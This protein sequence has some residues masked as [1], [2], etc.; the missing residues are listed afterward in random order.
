[1]VEQTVL[2][3]PRRVNLWLEKGSDASAP[4][5]RVRYVT[6]EERSALVLAKKEAA[7]AELEE[8]AGAM[9]ILQVIR[10]SGRPLVGHNFLLDLLF[11]YSHFVKP[12]LP[13][14][15]MGF[16]TK[17]QRL[18]SDVRA[19]VRACEAGWNAMHWMVCC[20]IATY[21]FTRSH[22]FQI[23]DTKVLAKA[24]GVSDGTGD[25]NLEGLYKSLSGTDA[26]EV[27]DDAVTSSVSGAVAGAGAG[28]G[29]TAAGENAGQLGEGGDASAHEAGHDAFMTGVVFASL[30]QKAAAAADSATPL[31]PRTD[32]PSLT[33]AE[34]W[35]NKIFMRMSD[36]ETFELRNFKQVRANI[37]VISGEAEERKGERGEERRGESRGRLEMAHRGLS[38]LIPPMSTGA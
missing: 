23:Y 29:A 38:S 10:A 20:I 2:R 9:R 33:H 26:S 31:A 32:P 27:G 22:S 30:L 11:L 13:E 24:L 7:L 36:I 6:Q 15:V 28:A 4:P 25:T 19:C 35:I 34:P 12:V 16:K 8:A 17:F 3:H 1:M 5:M 21:R 37:N 18:F 14:T